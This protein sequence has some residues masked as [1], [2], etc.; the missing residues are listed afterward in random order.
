MYVGSGLSRTD[1]VVIIEA[2]ATGCVGTTV[3]WAG[4]VSVC[5]LCPDVNVHE[6]NTHVYF[7]HTVYT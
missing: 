2:L 3:C 1:T 6:L 5:L 7:I 4:L